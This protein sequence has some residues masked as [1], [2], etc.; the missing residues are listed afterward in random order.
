[1]DNGVRV[2]PVPEFP[3]T[4]TLDMAP[5]MQMVESFMDARYMYTVQVPVPYPNGVD[6]KGETKYTQ[7]VSTVNAK[8]ITKEQINERRELRF[9]SALAFVKKWGLQGQPEK[10]NS[11]ADLNPRPYVAASKL[12]EWLLDT[13]YDFC[14]SEREIP[15]ALLSESTDSQMT[16]AVIQNPEY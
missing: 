2:S 9:D 16:P 6:E 14:M 10:I 7:I 15:K 4:I 8:N 1:M 13:V 11:R 3:G 5:T 12:V